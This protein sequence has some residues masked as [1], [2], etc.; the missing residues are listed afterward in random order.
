[1]NKQLIFIMCFSCCYFLKAQT[2]TVSGTI[3]DADT[4]ETLLGVNIINEELGIG[5]VSNAYGFYSIQLPKGNT[6]LQFS[7]LGYTSITTKLDGDGDISFPILL[8]ENSTQLTEVIIT[9]E[10]AEVSSRIGR[11]QMSALK[12][13]ANTIKRTSTV[14]GESDVLQTITLLPGIT[15][16]GEG[17]S[18]FNV[19]GGAADQNLV[20]LDEATVYNTSHLFGFFS[21]F[22]PLALKDVSLYKGG[23]PSK[24]GGRV[25]SVL[26]I[27]QRDGNTKEFHLE[28]GLGLIS[29]KVLV[30]GPLKKDKGS[31]LLAGRTSYVNLYLGLA[32]ETN[33]ASFYDINAKLSYE[34]NKRNKLLFSAYFGN[35]GFNDADIF[36]NS[37]GN[38]TFNLRWNHLYGKKLFSNLSLIHSTYDYRLTFKSDRLKWKSS[39]KNYNLK[40][41]FNYYLSN[42]TKLN[43]GL[44]TEYYDFNPGEVSGTDFY[45]EKLD[46]KFAFEPAIY[47]EADQKLTDKLVLRYGI[48]LNSFNRMGGQTIYVYE[49]DLP[50]VYDQQLQVY[51]SANPIT[52]E[53]Y[54]KGD[55]IESFFGWEPRISLSYNFNETASFKASYQKINQYLHLISNTNAPTPLDVWAPSGKF[56]EPQIA[57]QYAI[58]F[59]KNLSDNIYTLEIEG[60][61]KDVK[62][63]ID[64]IDG[65]D[66]IANNAIE[67]EILSGTARSYGLELLLRKNKG[68]FS[69]WLSY[70][71]SKSEQRVPG[72]TETEVGINN[73]N[74][75]NTPY[76]RTH[77]LSLTGV[78]SLNEK[79]SFSS[80]FI[81]QT[82]RPSNFPSGQYEFDGFVVPVFTERNAERLPA[83]HRLDISATLTPRKNKNRKWQGEWVFGLYNLYNRA[84]A[85]SITFRNDGNEIVNNQ[86]SITNEAVQTSIFGIVPGITYNFKF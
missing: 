43:F 21:V 83:Y 54:D 10:E 26:D 50:V 56:I 68:K 39:I 69:G 25:A 11:A 61:Y 29:T 22:N 38:A 37:Y 75:Y 71:L 2:R 7:F 77:D 44:N 60:Y 27:R 58:G 66:L 16:A 4:G 1:M 67:T 85:A 28:G 6:S 34:F 57:D 70:T 18:G 80:N 23:I 64:Y 3:S 46:N 84:N 31:F 81:Y 35:D 53:V 52:N 32:G 51:G 72:R 65:A 86:Q 17:A 19:R 49:D 41:D 30:E 42:T 33:K 55:V 48:R 15:N 5:T 12:L 20:L 47:V 76:D 59:F 36:S 40:Y 8:K 73:G 62:N 24:F 14:L 9:A 79:W 45:A 78:Y 63:R 74:W 82:G 13:D